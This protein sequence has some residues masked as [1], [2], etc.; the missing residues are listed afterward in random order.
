MNSVIS[1]RRIKNK[2]AQIIKAE[3]HPRATCFQPP[4]ILSSIARYLVLSSALKTD[5]INHGSCQDHKHTDVASISRLWARSRILTQSWCLS[6]C[7]NL[8]LN[9]AFCG[10]KWL[11]HRILAFPSKTIYNH[12]LRT[13]GLCF[14]LPSCG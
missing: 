4:L 7:Q 13:C 11:L 8:I 1:L 6:S 10:R 12:Q 2:R 14:K 9:T 3:L 5:F